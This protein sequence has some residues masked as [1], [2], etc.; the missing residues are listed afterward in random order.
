M[1]RPGAQAGSWIG[2][3]FWTLTI[4]DMRPWSAIWPKAIRAKETAA[5]YGRSSSWAHELKEKLAVDL[6]EYFG[7][8]A[9]AAAVQVPAWRGNTRT[10]H[11]KAACR[12]DRRRY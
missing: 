5:R 7:E 3:G 10:E 2:R 12:A 6:R 11:E 9:I 4:P 8:E 1:I